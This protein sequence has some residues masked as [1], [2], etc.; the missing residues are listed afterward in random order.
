MQSTHVYAPRPIAKARSLARSGTQWLPVSGFVTVRFLV[1]YRCE[2]PRLRA[3]VPEPFLLD[4]RDGFGF[5]SVCGL[6]VRRMGVIGAPE[7]LRFDNIEFLY[8]LA[9]RFRGEPTFLTLRSDVSARALAWLGPYFSH[10]RPHHGR[11]TFSEEQGGVR[12]ACASP[13]GAG[14]GV[15]DAFLHEPPVASRSI[16]SSPGEAADWLLGMGYSADAVRGRVRVQPIEHDPWQARFV[17]VRQ[18]RFVFL[19]RLEGELPCR[20]ELDCAL[21]TH[22]VR[23]WWRAARWV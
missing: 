16:F 1:T 23:Q 10:Y 6:K 22:G 21:A 4:E 2:A 13:D 9:I 19:E 7:V 5:L 14:D 3:L 17:R 18:A 15:L 20:F 12:I 8:R 11:F